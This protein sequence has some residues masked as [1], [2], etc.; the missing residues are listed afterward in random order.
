MA[1][2]QTPGTSD[3][4]LTRAERTAQRQEKARILREQEAKRRKRNRLIVI[5]ACVVVLALVVFIAVKIVTTSHA[6]AEVKNVTPTY[7]IA[8][9]DKGEATASEKAGTPTIRIYEDPT[10]PHCVEFHTAAREALAQ[11]IAAGDINVVYQP[12]AIGPIGPQYYDQGN[13]GVTAEFYVATHAP[14]QFE[15]FHDALMDGESGLFALIS[16]AANGGGAVPGKDQIKT[17]AEQAGVP[18]DVVAGMAKEFDS[19]PW[20]NYLKNVLQGFRDAG[21]TGTPTV[22]LNGTTVESE[23]YGGTDSAAIATWLDQVAA[24]KVK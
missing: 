20:N 14:A 2:K 18:A 16:K 22:M 13:W 11:H 21:V 19:A 4:K 17:Y 7:G 23:T 8:V 15:A 9:T 3:A 5:L 1:P 6:V 12:A 24:G 10:C